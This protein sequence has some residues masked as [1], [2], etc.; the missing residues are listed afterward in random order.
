MKSHYD[1][2]E[3][4]P[5]LTQEEWKYSGKFES[6]LNNTSKLTIICQNKEE[7][8]VACRPVVRKVL[9]NRL[10]CGTMK[11]ISTDD[12][13]SKKIIPHP[14]RSEINANTFTT[15]GKHV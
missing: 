15:S 10:S 13:G 8:N 11:F 3:A 2:F 6:I 14:T 12:W 9:H 7:L 5:F 1:E 4:P